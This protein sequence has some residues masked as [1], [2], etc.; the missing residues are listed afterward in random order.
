MAHLIKLAE[1]D[2]L[3][4]GRGKTLWIGG[5]EITVTNH[6][7]RYVATAPH[8]AGPFAPEVAE[9]ACE[10]PG[11]KFDAE[12]SAS[13]ARY[14]ADELTYQVVVRRDGIFV[15]VEEGHAHPGT[16]PRRPPRRRTGGPP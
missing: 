9:T 5:R 3:P 16:E 10:M 8:A 6:E 14:R 2:E 7:G 12:I 1:L 4:P 11:R 15:L 13:P